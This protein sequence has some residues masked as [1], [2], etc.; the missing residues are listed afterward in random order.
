MT[1]ATQPSE[2]ATDWEQEIRTL[3][4]QGRIAFLLGDI[5]TLD[6][7]MD[8]RLLVNSPLNVVNDKAKVLDLLG[9][10]LIRHTRDDVTIEHIARTIISLVGS[11]SRIVYR[12]LPQDDPKQRQPDITRAQT[13]LGWQP[14]VELEEGLAKTV[15]Y[16]KAKLVA[17]AR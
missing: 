13:L 9:K 3:E 1:T 14:Q 7:L 4:E 15:G 2:P 10:G 5:P 17:E 11:T 12:P 6:R 8:D 16:F